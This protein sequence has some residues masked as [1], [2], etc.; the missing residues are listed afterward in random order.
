MI[1][2]EGKPYRVLENLGFQSGYQAREVDD[3]GIPRVAVKRNGVW[4]WWTA[5]DKLGFRNVEAQHG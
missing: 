1:E 3:N 2:I 4:T 5:V